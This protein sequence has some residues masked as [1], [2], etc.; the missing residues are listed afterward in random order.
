MSQYLT[1]GINAVVD[2]PIE[3]IRTFATVTSVLD[4]GLYVNLVLDYYTVGDT[5]LNKIPVLQ[6]PYLNL[7]VREGDKVLLVTTSH[8]LGDY[9]A[10]GSFLDY[11]GIENYIA[12]PVVL[13]N[14]RESRQ[15]N[16][17]YHYLNP[18][19]TYRHSIDEKEE[20]IE[21]EK[22]DKFVKLQSLLS[23]YSKDYS[24]KANTYKAEIATTSETTCEDYKVTINNSGE[25][26]AN[27]QLT[28][29]SNLIDLGSD[30]VKIGALIGQ[31]IDALCAS[32]TTTVGGPST[33]TGQTLDRG[34][35]GT[36]QG[37]KAQLQSVFS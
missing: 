20:R 13:Q 15:F 11:V 14:V 1:Q 8:L 23:E 30:G 26:K 4:E 12:I 33:Q 31:M 27:T 19:A 32:M 2:K 6:N 29:N 21:G 10:T 25:I 36:L 24:L 16:N 9:Y 3:L 7:P 18:E 37:V 35:I 28:L 22:I 17:N 34:A 5:T